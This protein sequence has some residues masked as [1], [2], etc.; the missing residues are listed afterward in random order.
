MCDSQAALRVVD[1]LA[2]S[3]GLVTQQDLMGLYLFGSLANDGFEPERSDL[4]LLKW[5]DH[6]RANNFKDSLKA[7]SNAIL[8]F[9]EWAI[10]ESRSSVA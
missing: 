5:G 2:R 3:I 7:Q 8:E 10:D 9:V 6:I 1:D 4:D